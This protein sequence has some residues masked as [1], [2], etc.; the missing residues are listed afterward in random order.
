M[1]AMWQALASIIAAVTAPV[2]GAAVRASRRNRLVGRVRTLH[3]L[4][5]E[6]EAHDTAGAAALRALAAR[7]VQ[8]LAEI[9]EQ[10]LRRRFDPAAPFAFALFVLPAA[11]ASFFAWKYKGWWTWPVLLISAAWTVIV[12][13]AAWSQFWKEREVAEQAG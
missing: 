4:A 2:L 12:I 3:N 9:E 1:P 13:V 6:I 7:R 11:L 8:Q 10:A 5:D